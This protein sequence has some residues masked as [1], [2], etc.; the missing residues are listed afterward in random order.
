MRGV[1]HERL[2]CKAVLHELG[3]GQPKP[4]GD[5][6]GLTIAGRQVLDAC[7]Q[8]FDDLILEAQGEAG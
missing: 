3:F 4:G 2:Q 5:E 7:L 6:I 1:Q 8:P